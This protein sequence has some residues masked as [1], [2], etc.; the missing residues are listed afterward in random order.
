MTRYRGNTNHDLGI[1]RN[2]SLFEITKFVPTVL[3]RLK[4]EFVDKNKELQVSNSF[5]TKQRGL[6]CIITERSR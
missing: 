4:F 6:I 3:R 5:F 2:I 1:G